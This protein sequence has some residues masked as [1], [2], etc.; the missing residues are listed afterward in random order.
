MPVQPSREHLAPADAEPAVTAPGLHEAPA[1][2][3]EA[4]AA[5]LRVVGL[6][7][8][9]EGRRPVDLVRESAGVVRVGLAGQDEVLQGTF[10]LDPERADG[11]FHAGVVAQGVGG[12]DRVEGVADA[13]GRVRVD[14]AE[15]RIDAE[16]EDE[17]ELPG[18]VD[19]MEDA[20]VVGVAVT[21]RDVLHGQRDL[22]D[23]VFV[24]R[25]G[26]VVC[27]AFPPWAYGG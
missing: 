2:K 26:A 13:Q 7:E 21:G 17:Q 10:H 18:G 12:A 25:D 8:G 16:A 14:D 22:M 9:R 24:E 27:H 20:A 6:P 23:R 11:E 4:A 19:E 5:A 15:V 1:L 3:G